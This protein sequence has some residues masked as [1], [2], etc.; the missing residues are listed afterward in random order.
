MFIVTKIFRI[1]NFGLAWTEHFLTR[2]PFGFVIILIC[3]IQTKS[4][5]SMARNTHV[6]LN[7]NVDFIQNIDNYG[8]K[9]KIF[10]QVKEYKKI[11][12]CPSYQV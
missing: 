6:K 2:L 3:V 9:G 11:V 7:N 8:G 12:I 4:F 10:C 1:L 5:Y